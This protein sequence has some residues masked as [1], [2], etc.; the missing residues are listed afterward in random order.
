M[1]LRPSPE[2]SLRSV[3][4]PEALQNR[5]GNSARKVQRQKYDFPMPH[6]MDF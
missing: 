2:T 4:V 1:Q 3:L 6:D 5:L